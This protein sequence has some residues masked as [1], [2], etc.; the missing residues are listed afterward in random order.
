[1]LATGEGDPLPSLRRSV[2]LWQEARSPYE[3]ARV[4]MALGTALD[5]AGQPE[6]ARRELAAARACFDRL[7][8]RLDAE[9]AA[10]EL[11]IMTGE[12]VRS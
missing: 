3:S 10:T 5:R 2:E 9:A 11:L 7:G 8:A 4:R 6:A 12:Q 1:M